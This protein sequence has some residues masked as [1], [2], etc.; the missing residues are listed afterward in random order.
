MVQ[1]GLLSKTARAGGDVPATK[2]RAGPGGGPVWRPDLT[3]VHGPMCGIV[4]TETAR[5]ILP[6]DSSKALHIA[7]LR[8]GKTGSQR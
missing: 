6:K 5:R 3:T 2:T 8:G 1:R 4:T 7:F